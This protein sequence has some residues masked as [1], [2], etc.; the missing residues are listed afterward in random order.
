[1][2]ITSPDEPDG[3]AGAGKKDVRKRVKS[4]ASLIQGKTSVITALEEIHG[5]AQQTLHAD[6][7][8]PQRASAGD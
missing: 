2:E 6:G 1:V 7:S 5:M 4:L 3:R 8:I